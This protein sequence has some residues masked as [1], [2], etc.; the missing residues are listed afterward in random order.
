MK[1]KWKQTVIIKNKQIIMLRK[2][3]RNT[4]IDNNAKKGKQ[5]IM[6]SRNRQ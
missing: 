6:E 3:K 2:K 4:E 5:P 1:K